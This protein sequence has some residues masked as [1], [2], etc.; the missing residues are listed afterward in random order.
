MYIPPSFKVEDLDKLAAVIQQYSFATVITCSGNSPFA[1]HLP[2]LYRPERES[3]GTLVSHMARAN[4]QW[5]HFS[6]GDEV[7]TI[8]QGPHAYV[9]PSWY[10]TVLAVPTWNYVT[11][12]A[13]GVPKLIECETEMEALLEETI[14]KY[15]SGFAKPR[16][17][18]LSK[19]FKSKLI[20]A[21]V[22][23]EI[24][25]TRIE[26]KF[27]LGQNKSSEDL[28]GVYQNLRTSQY[29]NDRMLAEIMTQEC[30]CI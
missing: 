14:E 26:G 11:V 6:N 27:K 19:E 12:H 28:K 24:P 3:Y 9:S 20:K 17:G 25:I 18:A 22:G 16:Q 29:E 15:E 30:D 8:F 5:Q 23:F 2:V 21:I 10:E 13:Y 7:L 1:S 4:P